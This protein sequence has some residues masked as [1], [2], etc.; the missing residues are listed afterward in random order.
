[1]SLIM[2]AAVGRDPGPVFILTFH[3]AKDLLKT[4]NPAKQLRTEPHFVHKTTLQLPAAD[5]QIAG[6]PVN[7]SLPS[8]TDD[9]RNRVPQ[10]RSPYFFR[11]HAPDQQSFDNTDFL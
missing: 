3:G 10:R 4:Q 5:A 6:N 2:I 7:R 8:T 11:V 9:P 1:M